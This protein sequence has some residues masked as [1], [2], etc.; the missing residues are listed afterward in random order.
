LNPKAISCRARV[1]KPKRPMLLARQRHLLSLLLALGGSSTKLDFQKLLFLYCQQFPPSSIYDFVPYKFGAF[2]F[3]S[4][5]DRRKLVQIGLLK[6]DDSEWRITAEG[7]SAIGASSDLDLQEFAREYKGLRGEKLVAETYRRF[8]F[9]AIH[10]E[11]AER[12]LRGD[13]GALARINNAR[14]RASS[15]SLHTI[16]YEGRTLESY[17]T[18]LLV[19]GV[20]LLCDVRRNPISRKYGFSKNTLSS[21]CAGVGISYAHIPELGIESEDRQNLE[22]QEDYDALFNRY[23]KSSLPKQS[24]SLSRIRKWISSGQSVALTCYERLPHQC[25]RHCVAEALE[26]EA[27]KGV[28]TNHI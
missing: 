27:G 20:T 24:E 23:E 4:Y 15:A 11:I 22:S 18:S 25:H 14:P 28:S 10:S 17:L 16:G 26:N 6:E 7:C 13:A 1:P 21:G 12:V 8:P 19:H 5:A 3:T 9:F 2:S